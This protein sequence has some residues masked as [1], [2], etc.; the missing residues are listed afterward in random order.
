MIYTFRG[1]DGRVTHGAL[2]N[3]DGRWCGRRRTRI[4][5]YSNDGDKKKMKGK[6]VCSY[7][8]VVPKSKTWHSWK[9]DGVGRGK[10]RKHIVGDKTVGVKTGRRYFCSKTQQINCSLRLSNTTSMRN[11]PF[12]LCERCWSWLQCLAHRLILNWM[13]IRQKPLPKRCPLHCDW[14]R[15]L[16]SLRSSPGARGLPSAIVTDTQEGVVTLAAQLW[17]VLCSHPQF[18]LLQCDPSC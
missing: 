14:E 13:S 15:Y 3:S 17:G 2:L 4:Q 11:I 1:F 16:D 6:T 12:G 10:T 9:K 7:G 5:T 18:V 8:R